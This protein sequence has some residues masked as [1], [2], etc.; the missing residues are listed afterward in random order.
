MLRYLILLAVGSG[1]AWGA[2]AHAGTSGTNSAT[3]G[4][5]T[6][7]SGA[8]NNSQTT[9]GVASG[10]GFATNDFI[11]LVTDA[12]N[13]YEIVKCTANC[14]TTTMTITRAQLGTAAAAHASGA[15][16]QR[17]SAT[18]TTL[19]VT[20][21][22]AAVMIIVGF[23]SCFSPNTT[24]SI[25]DSQSLTWRAVNPLAR[26]ATP[27]N[28][29]WPV[30]AASW[31]A[32]TNG[33]S[34]TTVT[35]TASQ[36]DAYVA[37]MSD[38]FTGASLPVPYDP[39]ALGS[40]TTTSTN[41]SVGAKTLTGTGEAMWGAGMGSTTA[42]AGGYTKGADDTGGDMTEYKLAS[43]G[44]NTISFTQ[45]ANSNLCLGAAFVAAAPVGQF[46]RAN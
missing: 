24:L 43:S 26:L 23:A 35:I 45:T 16:V 40:V 41:C 27:T 6:T 29:N 42:V 3:P 17:L 39:P 37:V 8:I 36:S 25:S 32:N 15:A 21:V 12:T 19:A 22:S 13:Q 10:T 14:T 20:Q 33:T 46:A 4:A 18:S 11:A 31:S 7:L 30:C 1:I 2:I 28:G 38:Q 44:S 34:S 9:M 5:N